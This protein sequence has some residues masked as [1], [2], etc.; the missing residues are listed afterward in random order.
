MPSPV[1][2]SLMGYLIYRITPR[3]RREP[4]WPSLLTCV[5]VANAPDL[6]FI[7]G[8]LLGDPRWYHHDGISNSLGAAVLF[9]CVWSLLTATRQ[10]VALWKNAVLVFCLYMS[11]VGL[12]I[13]GIKRDIPLFWPFTT[14]RYGAAIG[15]LPGLDLVDGS[16]LTFFESL[17]S[18]LNVGVLVLEALFMLPLIV[19]IARRSEYGE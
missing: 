3:E 5:F 17:F 7:P 12:D 14:T 19:L 16:N 8:V 9:T 4:I 1:A 13:L 6:D 2:H 18:F 10:H 11:H 15:V